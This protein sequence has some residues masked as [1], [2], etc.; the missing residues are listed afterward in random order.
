LPAGELTGSHRSTTVRRAAYDEAIK[1]R[2]PLTIWFDP[3]RPR[4]ATASHADRQAWPA[5]GGLRSSH[6]TCPTMKVLLGLALWQTTGFVESLLRVSGLVWSVLDIGRLFR[7][8]EMQDVS[9]PHR[10][11]GT[12]H[13]LILSCGIIAC[14]LPGNG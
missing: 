8:R 1:R 12:L 4:K 7:R 10:G 5:A 3:E 11:S 2:G 14:C 9:I 13:L 6:Q